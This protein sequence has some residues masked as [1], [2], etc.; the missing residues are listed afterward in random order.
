MN[1]SGEHEAEISNS[2]SLQRVNM[3]S[4]RKSETAE[5]AAVQ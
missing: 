3:A 4:K 1:N 2:N 5:V